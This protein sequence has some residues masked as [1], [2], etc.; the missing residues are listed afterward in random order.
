[1]STL[2]SITNFYRVLTLENP[3]TDLLNA[4]VQRVD[5]AL[6]TLGATLKGIYTS[7]SVMSGP[8][9]E[10]V[11]LFFIAF[12]RAPDNYLYH[13]AMNALRSGVSLVDIANVALS[14]TGLPLSNDG[15]VSNTAF[16]NSLMT[17]VLG[18]TSNTALAKELVNMLDNQT[19]T[20]GHLLAAAS[21][22]KGQVKVA[23]EAD[24]ET[25]LIYLAA[26]SREASKAELEQTLTLDETIIAALRSVGI[27]AT[28]GKTG[29]TRDD[30]LITLYSDLA[31]DMVWDWTNNLFK[32]GGATAFKVFYSTDQ[33]LSG[34]LVDFDDSLVAGATQ[35]DARDITGKGKVVFT[36]TS[37]SSNTFWAPASGSNAT[38]GTG[39]DKFIG[40]EGTD[41]FVATAGRDTF[42]GGIGIDTFTLATSAIYQAG[43][44]LTTITDFG[45]GKDVL[46]LTRLLNKSVDVTKLTAIMADNTSAI[47]LGNGGVALVENNGAWVTGTGTST[48]SRPADAYDV[49]ALF[50]PGKV[51]ADPTQVMKAVV[52]TADTVDSADVWLILNSTGVTDIT[53]GITGPQEVFKV[54]HLDGS[55]NASLV[56]VLPVI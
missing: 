55:W 48:T 41:V 26:A 50:G 38:G 14:Y 3:S 37:S 43:A 25:A 2:S 35:L 40:N 28:G 44:S 34:S 4:Q 12:D 47:A 1:M 15:L 24:V 8:A 31:S 13:L 11:R 5:G 16:V 54:A 56:G 53:D 30:K 45:N 7:P 42:T 39:N 20:R 18:S 33:G 49:A 17:R 52:I 19:Q 36:G 23:A 29:L 51:F 9:D 10:L 27:S 46:D 22:M 32:A 6:S 21:A